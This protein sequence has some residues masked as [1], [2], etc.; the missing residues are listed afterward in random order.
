MM[1]SAF[2]TRRLTRL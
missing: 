1:M 2:I